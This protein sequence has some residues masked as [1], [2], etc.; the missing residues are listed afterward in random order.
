MILLYEGIIESFNQYTGLLDKLDMV[1]NAISDSK[2]NPNFYNLD[3]LS[4][5]HKLADEKKDLFEKSFTMELDNFDRI[6]K[7]LLQTCLNS[8]FEIIRSRDNSV[9]K[10]YENLGIKDYQSVLF[11]DSI[12]K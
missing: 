2:E 6:Y 11:N 4:N 8:I 1:L 5:E 3:I 10:L 9:F 12:N 7:N